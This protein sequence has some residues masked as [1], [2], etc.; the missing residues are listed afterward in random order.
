MQYIASCTM[1]R[2]ASKAMC[3]SEVRFG[4]LFPLRQVKQKDTEEENENM[5]LY[6]HGGGSNRK[7]V[8]YLEE[9]KNLHKIKY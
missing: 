1:Q 9:S 8:C 5:L 4:N 7:S 6:A 3:H 2:T